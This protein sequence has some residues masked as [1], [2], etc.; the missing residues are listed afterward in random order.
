[1]CSIVGA[2]D[3]KEKTIP[4]A[5]IVLKEEFSDIS[6]EE[7]IDK[8]NKV[9]IKEYPEF[10]IPKQYVFRSDLPLTLMTK[11]DFKQLELESSQMNFQ[12]CKYID[13]T[14]QKIKS[15]RL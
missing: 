10:M 15:K 4:V 12:N 9:I 5:H 14:N 1:M 7:L 6:K 8:I 3:E 2:P 11:V 13:K